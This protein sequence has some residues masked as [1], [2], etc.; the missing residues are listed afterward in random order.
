MKTCPFDSRSPHPSSSQG[1]CEYHTM[2]YEAMEKA[3]HAWN[4][5]LGTKLSWKEFLH[6]L[7]QLHKEDSGLIGSWVLDLIQFFED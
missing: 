4:E 7:R 1:F 3:W 6:E 5:A 2:A